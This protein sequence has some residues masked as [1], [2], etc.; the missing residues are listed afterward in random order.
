MEKNSTVLT[1]LRTDYPK[2]SVTANGAK[3]GRFTF[4]GKA[5][6]LFYKYNLLDD[7]TAPK[8]IGIFITNWKYEGGIVIDPT[9]EQER[10]C[11]EV[12][13]LY[14]IWKWNKVIG[15]SLNALSG[16][17]SLFKERGR[18]MN[19]Y[20][21]LIPSKEVDNV[22]YLNKDKVEVYWTTGRLSG[23]IRNKRK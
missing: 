21:E 9:L 17:S 7:K 10:Y 15:K 8:R 18:T 11:E 12:V 16:L 13:N 19:Y 2:L 1:S 5:L 23:F 3:E 4:S 22:F 20:W 6:D 14:S